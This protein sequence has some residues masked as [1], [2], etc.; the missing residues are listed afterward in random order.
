V[1][2]EL[3][4]YCTIIP[5]VAESHQSAIASGAVMDDVGEVLVADT[6]MAGTIGAIFKISR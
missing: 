3:A 5:E 1:T 4:A 2:I 6:T